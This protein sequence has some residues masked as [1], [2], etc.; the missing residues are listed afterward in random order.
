MLRKVDESVDITLEED[1]AAI[2]LVG[3]GV[4]HL[5]S[6]TSTLAR[7]IA[8]LQITDVRLTSQGSSSLSFGFAIRE[9]DLQAAMEALHREFFAAP[10]GN[11]FAVREYT[12]V[13]A[14]Q[15]AQVG[16]TVSASFPPHALP[17]H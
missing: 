4:A 3:E 9:A 17:A 6:A 5:G 12:P 10:D 16:Q 13:H 11:V 15:A 7:A 8:A 2:W 1:R 14:S